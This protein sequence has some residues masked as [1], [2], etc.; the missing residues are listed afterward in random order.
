MS[1]SNSCIRSFDL[2]SHVLGFCPAI[3]DTAYESTMRSDSRGGV[4]AKQASWPGPRISRATSRLL[5]LGLVLSPLF[6][7]T[8][9]TDIGRRPVR[10]IASDILR[11]SHTPLLRKYSTSTRRA[12]RHNSGGSG[13]PVM[14]SM[15]LSFLSAIDRIAFTDASTN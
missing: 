9:R 3:S 7:S 2:G 12:S 14:S 4:G 13:C 10:W 5:I 6:T 11:N 1:S 8:Q 15:N